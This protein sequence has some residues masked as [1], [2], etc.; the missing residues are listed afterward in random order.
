MEKI[1][2]IQLIRLKRKGA[3]NIQ[4]Y[5]NLMSYKKIGLKIN[6]TNACCLII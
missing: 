1:Y 6:P 2:A 4:Q 5:T 3:I